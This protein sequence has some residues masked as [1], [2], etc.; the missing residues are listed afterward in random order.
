[1]QANQYPDFA[2]HKTEHERFTRTVL[3]CQGKFQRNEIGL[4]I[5]VMDLLKDWLTKHIMGVDK[6][7]APYLNARGVH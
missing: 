4:T 3:D 1:M 2:N 6:K 7:Y 5:E